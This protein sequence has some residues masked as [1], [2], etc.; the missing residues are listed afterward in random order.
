MPAR[1]RP[2]SGKP[3]ARRRFDARPDTTDF[4]D[5][6]FVPTL[7]EVPS[8]MPL[9][10]FQRSR[11]LVLDQGNEGAC[12]G[13]GLAAVSNHLL[14]I[15]KHLPDREPVSAR[16][17]YVMARRYDEWSGEDYEGSSARGAMKG[18]HKHGVCARELWPDDGD[19]RLTAV[20][21]SDAAQRPLGAYF[22]V[23]HGDLVA[24]HA[25][26]AEVGILFA[27]ATVHSGWDKTGKDGTIPRQK[28]VSGGHAFAIVGYDADGFWIQN[29]WGKGWGR[30]GFGH[31]SYGDWLENA[32]DVWVARLGAPVRTDVD[33]TA[34]F[35]KAGALTGQ[36]SAVA[37]RPH[38]VS[39]G[40]DGRLRRSGSFA[41]DE[42]DIREILEVEFPRITGSW[43]RKRVLLY[44]HGGL[45]SEKN[46]L[47]RI[48]NYL[49]AL[50]DAQVYPLAFVWKTDY[51]TTLS[52]ILKDALG[53]RRAEGI[54][55]ASKDFALDRIDDTLE[56][57]AR[58]L[59]G[60]AQWDEM[61]ENGIAAT[62]R[63]DG[64]ARFVAELLAGL[65]DADSKIEFHVAAHS[66]GSIFHA[67][68]VQYLATRGEIGNGPMRGTT[69]LGATIQSCTLWAPA[70][71]VELFKHSY[72][73][74][75]DEY[76]IADF[77]VY[78]LKKQ[79]EEDDHCAHVYNKSLLYLV[80]NAFETK[81]RIPLFRDGEAILGMH[82]FVNKDEE[83]GALFRK[84]NTS[85]VLAPNREAA[86]SA[87]ASTA[88]HHGDFDDDVPT[89]QALLARITGRD[90]SRSR[91]R[92][93][94][95]TSASRDRRSQLQ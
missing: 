22:R 95:S 13:F 74:L 90:A 76:R 36:F 45:V 30:Q 46:A 78:N 4:R 71:T 62:V 26:M 72:L 43:R 54:I 17:L 68:L 5:R 65:A 47:Q 69:G 19:N 58:L 35:A 41:N 2:A 81:P 38:V 16:M 60:K 32:M 10:N 33:G 27:T 92:F 63:A 48:E 75:I 34:T 8:E 53:H 57:L 77:A 31:L 12:T 55:D 61:K 1:K 67:P 28:R 94:R 79:A 50:L 25:A 40:N 23:D 37:L 59:T 7:I 11:P 56:P 87:G 86:G 80:S 21:G 15:R 39:I 84:R 89:L 6:V 66:A 44:A 3:L 82:K 42:A 83:L 64:G 18:W 9:E 20:C 29:S 51:W 73:E 85:Y 91:F 88:R 14:Q 93:P 24:M 49:P 70:C 52:N